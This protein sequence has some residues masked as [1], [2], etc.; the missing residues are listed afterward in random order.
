MLSHSGDI[1]S[2]IPQV[3]ECCVVMWSS[4]PHNTVLSSPQTS[5]R[6]RPHR[7]LVPTDETQSTKLDVE[8]LNDSTKRADETRRGNSL[9]ESLSISDSVGLHLSITHDVDGRPV[10]D[11][12]CTSS[13]C[14]FSRSQ[15]DHC[16]PPGDRRGDNSRGGLLCDRSAAL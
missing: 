11:R 8:T 4:R 16:P 7:P 12:T 14:G 15:L 10:T 9:I 3:P 2:P 13:V 5:L 1:A 6:S